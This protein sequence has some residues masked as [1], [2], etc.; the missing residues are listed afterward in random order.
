MGGK[1]KK[2]KIKKFLK[3]FINKFFFQIFIFLRPKTICTFSSYLFSLTKKN[4]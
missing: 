4:K 1:K 2:E 3:L